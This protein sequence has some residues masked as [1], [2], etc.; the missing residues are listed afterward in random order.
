MYDY[1]CRYTDD[2]ISEPVDG[3]S[4]R[5]PPLANNV[6]IYGAARS[7]GL[8]HEKN[9]NPKLDGSLTGSTRGRAALTS[10]PAGIF[11]EQKSSYTG[12]SAAMAFP[13]ILGVDLGSD[14]PPKMRSF[15]FNFG[16]R[17]EEA[18]NSHQLLGRLISEEELS[19]YSDVYFAALAP[20]G[21]M[22][23]PEIYAQRCQDL[24][25]GSGTDAFGAVAAGVASLGSFLSP[26]R[27]PREPDL[28]QY[29][30]AILDD[31]GSMRLVSIDHI[32]A[33]AMRVLY[34]RATTRPSNA[35]IASCTQMHLFETIGL[36]DETNIKKLSSRPGA[37]AMGH[38]ADR[39]RRIFWFSWSGHNMLSY[40]QDYLAVSFRDVTCQALSPKPGIFTDQFVKMIQI[41]PAPGSPFHLDHQPPGSSAELLE[42]LKVLNG[43]DFTHPFL[44]VT[45]ADIAFCFYRRIYQLKNGMP[46]E[47]I[48]LVIDSGNA[49]VRASRQLATQGRL[50][51]NVI[52]SVFQYACILLA[53]DTSV[54][55]AHIGTAFK[56]LE[57][58]VQVANTALTRE[59]LS[60][61]RHLLSLSM[62]KKRKQV[63]QMEA[64]EAGYEP[65]DA[66]PVFEDNS[67]SEM[68]DLDWDQ[69][70]MDP[71]LSMLGPD[72]QF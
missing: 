32:I 7:I 12:A 19:F 56:G 11:D 17:P 41:I 14:N 55:S 47:F 59:A 8:S 18:S 35:W 22:L 15:A 6:S 1:H 53:I 43:L 10:T 63:A 50:F 27:H 2:D 51:W 70:F 68:W 71:Y 24:Y 42:R 69:F 62:K 58:L 30:K 5:A 66:Q 26:N 45:K 67:G 13:H 39:L 31:P 29:A 20:I 23:D 44:V 21:D 4:A 64:V 61:A 25:L 3:G 36:Y 52:G 28:L 72:I 46:E 33:W 54:A 16:I 48:N 57:N 49:A 38:D 60:I 34:L 37:A 9:G 40:E 65:L